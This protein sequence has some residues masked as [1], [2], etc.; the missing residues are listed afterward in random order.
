VNAASPLAALALIAGAIAAVPAAAMPLQ[1]A[2][3]ARQLPK[4]T[5]IRLMVTKEVNSRSAK[6][7]ERF[8]L[9]VD[10]AVALNGATVIP[11][12]AIAWGEVTDSKGTT[13]AGGKGRLNVR[14]LYLDLPEGQL[15]I[16]GTRG[17]EGKS[18][19]TGLA[20]GILTF[21][22]GGLLTRGGNATLKAGEIFTAYLDSGVERPHAQPL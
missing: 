19:S 3:T 21:G 5:P 7:G 13:A 9:R 20:L 11:I 12:G 22:L 1:D 10:E 15:P 16:S 2:P 14:L 8:K 4:G 17:A 6:P 18:N